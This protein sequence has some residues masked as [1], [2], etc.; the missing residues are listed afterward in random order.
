MCS[1]LFSIL[2]QT[3][4]TS[5]AREMSVMQSDVNTHEGHVTSQKMLSCLP[6]LCGFWLQQHINEDLLKI[7]PNAGLTTSV[8]DS[9]STNTASSL[10]GSALSHLCLVRH[11]QRGFTFQTQLRLH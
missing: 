4:Q 11:A 9:V 8:L 2:P 1:S 7:I 5:F 3:S 6:S 10:S